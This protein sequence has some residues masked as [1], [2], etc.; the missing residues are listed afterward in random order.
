M[1]AVENDTLGIEERAAWIDMIR[2]EFVKRGDLIR[3]FIF[4]NFLFKLGAG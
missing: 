4:E 1:K 2:T 3:R